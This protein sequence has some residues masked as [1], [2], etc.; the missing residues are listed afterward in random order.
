M[1]SHVSHS[2]ASPAAVADP[3]TPVRRV[4]IAATGL[5][6][7]HSVRLKVAASLLLADFIH[8]ELV[9]TDAGDVDLLVGDADEPEAQRR[10]QAAAAAGRHVMAISRSGSGPGGSALAQGASVRQIHQQLV[11]LLADTTPSPQAA[12]RSVFDWLARHRQS[13]CLLH[14]GLLRF[15]VDGAR[16]R[17][18]LMRDLPL[19]RFAERLCQDSW[20]CEVLDAAGWEQA[21]GDAVGHCRWE[22]LCWHA[23]VLCPAPLPVARPSGRL[24]LR[25]WPELDASLLPMP[26]LIGL[27]ALLQRP[28]QPAQL[29]LAAGLP[30]TEVA[31]IA[32]AASWSG[33][34][35]T[36]PA[37]A[38]VAAAETVP[39]LLGR[40]A[41][42][43]GLRF[44]LPRP[45][46]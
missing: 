39:G 18:V 3:A 16:E 11:Y 1:I 20:S 4:R 37:A 46:H 27:S 6:M 28:W 10:L 32:A 31:R 35:D 38:R 23:A 41:R 42:R 14:N 17:V 34:L 43:F 2:M 45:G 15:C 22:T 25:G 29:A 8:A 44:P 12:A 30:S 19:E 36:A 5:D 24:G 7:L 33:L 21:M 26:W 9:E 40:L 13:P